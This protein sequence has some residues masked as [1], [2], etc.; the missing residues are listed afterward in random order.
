MKC[1]L[2]GAASVLFWSTAAAAAVVIGLHDQPLVATVLDSRVDFGVVEL[3]VNSVFLPSGI[4][5]VQ[6]QALGQFSV[7]Y[8]AA[9]MD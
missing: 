9:C 6:H 8:W 2:I 3:I 7:G 4:V 1:V 5:E